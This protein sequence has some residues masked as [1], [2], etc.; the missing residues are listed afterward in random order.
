MSLTTKAVRLTLEE[1][2]PVVYTQRG[3]TVAM[4][5]SSYLFAA[6]GSPDK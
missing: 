6:P 1:P 5:F 3:A 4:Y 2:L